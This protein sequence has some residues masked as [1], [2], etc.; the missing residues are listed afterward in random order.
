VSSMLSNHLAFAAHA[1]PGA[2]RTGVVITGNQGVIDPGPLRQS[3]PALPNVC[4]LRGPTSWSAA[5]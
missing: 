5:I 3:R 1:V 2:S 4:G